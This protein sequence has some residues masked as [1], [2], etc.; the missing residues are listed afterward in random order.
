MSSKPFLGQ[1]LDPAPFTPEFE[2]GVYTKRKV[3]Y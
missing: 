1:S 2:T 3:V